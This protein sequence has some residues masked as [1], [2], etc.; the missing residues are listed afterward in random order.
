MIIYE[1]DIH[2][3]LLQGHAM[4]RGTAPS[5]SLLG[6]FRVLCGSPLAPH[7]SPSYDIVNDLFFVTSPIVS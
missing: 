6:S 2:G 1:V 7:V 5:L 3:T 4:L